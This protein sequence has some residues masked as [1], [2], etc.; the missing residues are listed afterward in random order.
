M[1]APARYKTR[2]KSRTATP[3]R[4]LLHLR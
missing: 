3:M 1:A 2:S 4:A